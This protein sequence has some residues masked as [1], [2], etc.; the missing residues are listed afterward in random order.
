M[1]SSLV[2]NIT[3]DLHFLQRFHA[4]KSSLLE[5]IDTHTIFDSMKHL[6]SLLEIELIVEEFARQVTQDLVEALHQFREL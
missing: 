4:L 1:I 2:S 3:K 5:Y 6:E